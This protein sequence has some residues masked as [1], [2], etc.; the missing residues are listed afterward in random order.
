MSSQTPVVVAESN[1]L[2]A[3][4]F[5]A[6]L[7]GSGRPVV[8][9]RF[10]DEV[11]RLI[12]RH[13]ARVVVLSMNLARPSG[14]ELL[15]MMQQRGLNIRV[16]AAIGLGQSELKAAAGALGVGSFFELPF[17]PESLVA[18]VAELEVAS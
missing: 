7:Q 3:R 1:F 11:I 12:E 8:I 16:L 4:L 10:G 5:A 15:R 13:Q 2:T 6:T 17:S 14:L 9:G 18:R